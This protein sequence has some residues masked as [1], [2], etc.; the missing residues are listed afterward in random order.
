MKRNQIPFSKSE[1]PSVQWHPVILGSPALC[2]LLGLSPERD[3]KTSLLLEAQAAE[4]QVRAALGSNWIPVVDPR[5]WAAI[6]S[7]IAARADKPSS[8]L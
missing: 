3:D 1:Y 6:R 4:T 5:Q 8:K 7:E 2:E